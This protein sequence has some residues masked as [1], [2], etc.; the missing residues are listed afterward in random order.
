MG[1]FK[2][3]NSGLR[4]ADLRQRR[5]SSNLYVTKSHGCKCVDGTGIFIHA[6]RQPDPV[7]KLQAH[8][9]QG[10]MDHGLHEQQATPQGV[11][12]CSQRFECEIVNGFR[13]Q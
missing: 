4:V 11:L 13:I 8:Q 9:A 1:L 3:K 10:V 6:G 12:S 5:H 2:A 7:G